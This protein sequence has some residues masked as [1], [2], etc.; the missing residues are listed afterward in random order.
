[1]ELPPFN[2]D[3]L[4]P[5]GDYEMSLE[6]LKG[7]MLVKGPEEGYPSWDSEWWMKLVENMGVMVGQLRRVGITE[8]FVNGSFVED[9][10]HPNDI[11]GYFECNVVEFATGKTYRGSSTGSIHTR[12]GHG[13]QRA[14]CRTG[15]SQRGSYR[16][17]TATG[18]SSTHTTRDY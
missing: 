12:C 6:E 17:G 18:W 1:L 9:K 14:A 3:G 15:T 13:T 5:P 10:D 4:L 11:D 7:S 8:I 16:C 2:E